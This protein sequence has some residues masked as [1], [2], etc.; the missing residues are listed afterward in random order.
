RAARALR[1]VWHV[2]VG[3]GCG[4]G[5]ASSDRVT[6]DHASG[7]R[8]PPPLPVVCGGWGTHASVELG[9]QLRPGGG[10]N[11]TGFFEDESLMKINKRLRK[12]LGL[13]ADSVSLI[14]PQQWQTPAV[15]AFQ[16]EARETI[17]RRFG[18]Y[19]LWGYKYAGTLRMLPFWRAVFHS[20]DLDVGYVVALR[21][22]ISVARSRAKLN[23]QRGVQEKSDLEWLV[24]VV[25]Y[26]CEVREQPFVVVDY[27]L[28]MANPV[29]QLERI[30]ITL[31][32]R[33]TAN[34]QVA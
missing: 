23:P 22:P 29:A 19:P 17:R 11:P 10:K 20:L 18:H 8:I 9:A 5:A 7:D 2:I 31:N 13:R 27:D 6:P 32:L 12:A 25:P 21:N 28:L 14:E 1:A 33:I 24:N 34:T 26:F 4:A 3:R 30:A 15:Q 16:Q